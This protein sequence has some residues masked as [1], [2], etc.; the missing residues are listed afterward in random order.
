MLAP[1][2]NYED[3][4]RNFRGRVPDFY[5]MG[6]DVSD[7]HADGGGRLAEIG[8]QMSA[9]DQAAAAHDGPTLQHVEQLAGGP[10]PGL[11]RDDVPHVERR[12][13]VD[14]GALAL[15]RTDVR[16]GVQDLEAV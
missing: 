13:H 10:W 14:H 4:A 15:V 7:Q 2:A 12:P 6:V 1:A 11:P 3:L 8:G 5:N 16:R 9:A